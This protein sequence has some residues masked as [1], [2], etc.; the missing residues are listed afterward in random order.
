KLNMEFDESNFFLDENYIIESN[1]SEIIDDDISNNSSNQEENFVEDNETS[2]D[3]DETNSNQVNEEDILMEENIIIEENFPNTPNEENANTKTDNKKK[4]KSIVH[5]HFTIDQQA[6]KYKCNYC[7][8]TYKISKDK[9][10]SVLKRHLEKNHKK[11][12]AKEKTI[13]ALD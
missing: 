7:S 1:I 4:L 2:S 13:G 11:L 9:S 5:N 3:E 12:I 6:K 10:T 8:Q